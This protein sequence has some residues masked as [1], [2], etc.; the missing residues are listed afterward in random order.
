MMNKIKEFIESDSFQCY[1]WPI[2]KGLYIVIATAALMLVGYLFVKDDL[3]RHLENEW[4]EELAV[5][6]MME[7]AHEKFSNP[8]YYYED[9]N[10][11]RNHADEMLVLFEDNWNN[12]SDE[13]KEK[14]AE[15]VV[16]KAARDIVHPGEFK[17]K[18]D[19]L[20]YDVADFDYNNN[21]IIIDANYLYS[22]SSYDVFS[23][24]YHEMYKIHAID[25]VS[26]YRHVSEA[27]KNLDIFNKAKAYDKDWQNAEL[28]DCPYGTS[29]YKSIEEDAEAFAKESAYHFFK[30]IATYQCKDEIDQI[31]LHNSNSSISD[32]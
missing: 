10:A 6:Q 32:R 25:L 1:I 24:I 3:F 18:V 4:K 15:Q 28:I 12:A 5:K 8:K 27:S 11:Y 22:A 16:F 20:K 13:E 2:L 21:T 29:Y 26:T 23:C 7:E 30:Y 19:N 14:G 17:L 31:E 9:Y